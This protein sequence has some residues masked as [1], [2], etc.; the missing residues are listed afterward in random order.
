MLELHNLKWHY[1]CYSRRQWKPVIGGILG[2][3]MRL[4]LLTQYRCH[5]P[6]PA[7][8]QLQV[9]TPFSMILHAI[10]LTQ[11]CLSI[12][13]SSVNAGVACSVSGLELANC[14][15]SKLRK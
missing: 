7:A 4:T 11:G 5:G 15:L 6:T 10:Q 1:L 13:I 14:L 3:A 12:P 9:K 2:K 8:N